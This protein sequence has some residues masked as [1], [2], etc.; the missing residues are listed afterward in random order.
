[1]PGMKVDCGGAAAILGA[2]IVAV[3][4]GFKVLQGYIFYKILWW[5]LGESM[6]NRENKWV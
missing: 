1:M 5:G 4:S 3:K 2:F 6:T